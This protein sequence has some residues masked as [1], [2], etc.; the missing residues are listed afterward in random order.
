MWPYFLKVL[1][2]AKIT[3]SVTAAVHALAGG[4]VVALP[5]ETVY[6]L[7]ASL[8]SPTAIERIFTIKGRPADHPLIVHVAAGTDLSI[9][10]QSVP[11]TARVLV[12]EFW[13][14]PLTLVLP[15]SALVPDS[16]TGGQ[17][18]VAL[19]APA[20]EQFQAVLHGLEQVTGQPAAIAAPSANLF[21]Q[22]SPTT[23][24]HVA[25]GLGAA[26]GPADLIL[27]AGPS[28]V[29]IESTIVLCRDHDVVILRPGSVTQTDLARVAA[30][31][32]SAA[33]SVAGLVT[34][35]VGDSVASAAGVGANPTT[36]GTDSSTSTAPVKSNHEINSMTTP[37]VSGSLTAHYSPAAKV[38]LVSPPE[39]LA[40]VVTEHLDAGSR[41]GLI[42][43][44]WPV[45]SSGRPLA[46]ATTASTA[47][48][49]SLPSSLVAEVVILSEPYNMG[50][51]AAQLY[52]SLRTADDLDLDVVVAILPP[53]TGIGIA[54]RDRL[55]R[56]A[57]G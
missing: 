25:Q 51:Y 37:R 48:T 26:L 10:A 6:G 32:D 52:T 45:L 8:G 19:R 11:A 1:I 40:T 20:N 17:P 36:L 12:A 28:S 31:V 34:G 2:L 41:I 30:V 14:G 22:V 33:D 55:I 18:T 57:N 43:P 23:A 5:T 15:K 50:E 39:D 42:W 3:T 56:A 44:Q 4:N 53:D 21:G 9:W 46:K 24:A 49:A 54:I 29:G 7:G 38:V 13:P 47:T 27:D 35:P 16:V